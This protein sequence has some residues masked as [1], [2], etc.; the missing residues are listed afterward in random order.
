M[1]RQYSKPF[2]AGNPRLTELSLLIVRLSFG[3]LIFYQHGLVKLQN[4]N[5]PT[6]MAGGLEKIGIPFPILAAWLAALAEAVGGLLL[7]AGLLT[8]FASF[9]LLFVM[10]VAIFGMHGGDPIGKFE[11]ALLYGAVFLFFTIS[12]GG[13]WSLDHYLHQALSKEN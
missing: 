6:G 5:F 10:L 1:I 13:R 12:G 7:A 11:M 3:F 2:F 9:A 8:R 4:E